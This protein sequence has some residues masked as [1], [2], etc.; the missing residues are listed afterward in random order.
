[1]FSNI[2]QG[3][4]L[5]LTV[6]RLIAIAVGTFLGYFVGAMPGL[7]PSIG[8]ALLIPFTFGMNPV[9]GIV[10]L[11]ALY[12]AAEYGGGITAILVNAPGTPA[13]A[14]TAWDGYPMAQKGQAGKALTI[15]I[16]SSGI[17]HLVSSVLLIFTAVS[18][19]NAAL[20]FG[21][22]ELFA[23]AV[24]GLSLVS[25]LSGKSLLKGFIA[26]L[27][28]LLCK[29]IGVD[30]VSG[31][32]RYAF[33]VH[34]LEG[35]P[36][37]PA[38]IGLFA[39]SEV[40]IMLEHPTE[41]M[42]RAERIRGIGLT[43]SDIKLLWKTWI[44]GPIVGYLIGVIPGAGATV[45]SFVSY[46]LAKRSSRYPELF[47]KGNPEGVAG[48]ETANNAA[49]GGALA[50]LL[51]L[52]IPGSATTAVMLGALTIHGIQPGPL[53]FAKN[54][55]IPYSVFCTL[56]LAIPFVVAVGLL[57]ARLWIWLVRSISKRTLAFLVSGICFVGAYSYSN[58]MYP[59][60]VMV[61]FGI[62]GYVLRKLEIPTAPIVLALVLGFMME[63]NF[64]RGLIVSGGNLLTFF[65]RPLTVLL[66]AAALAALL[67]PI[68][69]ERQKSSRRRPA[70]D[71]AGPSPK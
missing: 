34:L 68:L 29:V 2:L 38:L 44:R 1:M 4:H 69:S 47:G 63:V 46:D 71:Y 18:L 33:S 3:F 12:M 58:T 26:M 10:M 52:G 22:P 37:L 40:L 15:S 13:A 6:E 65:S 25:S 51:A 11:V 28:G 43:L 57:G 70:M 8:V 23:L 27:I 49:V 30:P 62:G 7:T 64:R 60:W 14:A 67:H 16:I 21:P 5:V 56:L 50:P 42:E 45:A 32:P 31:I 20:R 66:L 35:I 59:V 54:P 24:L 17:G 55:E 9:T 53:I 39:L 48:S 36:F 41:E 61:C 19:A